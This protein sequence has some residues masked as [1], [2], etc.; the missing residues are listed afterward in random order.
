MACPCRAQLL[1]LDDAP[2]VPDDGVQRR[3]TEEAVCSHTCTCTWWRRHGSTLVAGD[4]GVG[5]GVHQHDPHARH[6]SAADVAKSSSG[7]AGVGDE[8]MMPLVQAIH[9]S[10]S[11][12]ANQQVMRATLGFGR[13]PALG[14]SSSSLA[15]NSQYHHLG[16]A[17]SLHLHH[18]STGS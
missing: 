13:A 2:Q 4:Q 11:E 17:P 7:Q 6:P 10:C 3:L 16:L 18:L 9:A 8:L 15:A 1:T 5:P 12:I 14:G